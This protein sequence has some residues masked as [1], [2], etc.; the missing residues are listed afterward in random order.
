MNPM[1][2][3]IGE[4]A[5]LR[6]RVLVVDGGARHLTLNE[7]DALPRLEVDRRIERQRRGHLLGGA[8]DLERHRRERNNQRCSAALDD[9]R[10][11]A[12]EVSEGRA[13]GSVMGCLIEAAD[14]DATL[15]E[16]Q[17]V[18]HDVFGRNK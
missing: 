7:A 4:R 8:A 5:R 13:I 11:A 9:L 3:R 2:S 12:S 14:A 15:G 10:R 18:L 17:K 6:S 16:M 1:K